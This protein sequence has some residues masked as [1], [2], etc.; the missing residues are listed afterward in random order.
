MATF[1]GD[2]PFLHQIVGG[3][4]ACLRLL[5]RLIRRRRRALR[6]VDNGRVIW[7]SEKRERRSGFLLPLIETNPCFIAYWEKFA[8]W[9]LLINVARWLGG[10]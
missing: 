9:S 5:Y 10:G 7:W 8:D 6:R 3:R 1:D 4:T 2:L